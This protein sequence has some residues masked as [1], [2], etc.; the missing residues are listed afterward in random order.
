MWEL[1][2]RDLPLY[3]CDELHRG[4]RDTFAATMQTDLHLYALTDSDS[5]LLFCKPILSTTTTSIDETSDISI[6]V[7]E[8]QHVDY[9]KIITSNL[10]PE[11]LPWI[12]VDPAAAQG[13]VF[14][15]AHHGYDS[16][17]AAGV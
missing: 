8:A 3:L 15:L 13:V 17:V 12:C 4:N 14:L 9:S 10:R 7:S 16:S 2:F 5:S 6:D 11:H 1:F